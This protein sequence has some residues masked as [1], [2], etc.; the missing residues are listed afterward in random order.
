MIYESCWVWGMGIGEG[1]VY[2]RELDVSVYYVYPSRTGFG[3]VL[4]PARDPDYV[5][6]ILFKN[7]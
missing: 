7:Y 2:N 3:T 1:N 6:Q 4:I 5:L